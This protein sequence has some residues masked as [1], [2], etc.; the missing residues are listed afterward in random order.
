MLSPTA[1]PSLS[2]IKGVHPHGSVLHADGIYLICKFMYRVYRPSIC[3][4]LEDRLTGQRPYRGYIWPEEISS[5]P[6]VGLVV[7]EAFVR[8]VVGLKLGIWWSWLPWS[9]TACCT[10]P[11]VWGKHLQRCFLLL[12]PRLYSLDWFWSCTTWWCFLIGLSGMSLY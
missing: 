5:V 3:F 1:V 8:T 2:N 4:L 12:S 6:C 10:S 11:A 9:F 7:V